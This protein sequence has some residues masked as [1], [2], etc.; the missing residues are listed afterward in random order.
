M[1]FRNRVK[2]DQQRCI[3]IIRTVLN[4][5]EGFQAWSICVDVKHELIDY[6]IHSLYTWF[7]ITERNVNLMIGESLKKN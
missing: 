6:I 4:W 1:R 3:E 7:A 5:A 2:T